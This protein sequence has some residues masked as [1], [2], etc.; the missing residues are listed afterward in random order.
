MKNLD[1]L[2]NLPDQL[3]DLIIKHD[4]TVDERKNERLL[5]DI[6]HEKNT[7]SN[8]NS[9][10]FAL[11]VRGSFWDKKVGK[12]KQKTSQSSLPAKASN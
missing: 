12:I 1:K 5:Q 3:K 6:A 4:V 7:S 11:V 2:E 9:V 10:S 8:E